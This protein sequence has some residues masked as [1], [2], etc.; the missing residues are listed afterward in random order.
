[1]SVIL[2]PILDG[3]LQAWK[4]WAGELRGPAFEDF[5]NRYDLTRHVAWL[6]ETPAGPMAIVPIEGPGADDH[7]HRLAASD[8]EYDLK[9]RD[10]I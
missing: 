9:H 2:A 4:D 10:R 1:M 5:N 7:M 3:K 6:A 8:N